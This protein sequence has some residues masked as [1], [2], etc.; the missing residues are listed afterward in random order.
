MMSIANTLS[1]Y[2]N[3]IGAAISAA[4]NGVI[5][6]QTRQPLRSVYLAVAALS[7]VFIGV[8]I[9]TLLAP[10]ETEVLQA[11]FFGTGVAM[12]AWPI[13]WIIPPIVSWRLT[14]EPD[15]I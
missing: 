13:V 14:R 7:G 2:I 1:V 10:S 12:F 8:F 15:D 5:A 9:A 4:V 6:S 3:I 11:K